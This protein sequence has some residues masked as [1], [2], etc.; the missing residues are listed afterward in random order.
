ME[1]SVFE[2][3]T[4]E[5][6]SDGTLEWDSTTMVVVEVAHDGAV[7]LGYTYAD[8]SAATLIES[9]LAPLLEEHDPMS[10]PATWERM[11]A[12]LRNVGQGG[13]G[14]MA[15]SA[16]D[17][18]LWDLKAKLLGVCLADVLPRFHESVPIYGSGGVTA[19]SLQRLPHPRAGRA[20]DGNSRVEN[21]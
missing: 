8:R 15:L 11:H 20:G 6:E 19:P 4:D 16:V 17:I 21:K 9:K 5:P 3:P 7:G 1:V 10:P 2:V 18:A 12:A 13:L 14:A